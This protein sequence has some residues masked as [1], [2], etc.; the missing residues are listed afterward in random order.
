MTT[1]HHGKFCVLDLSVVIPV[2]NE[3]RHLS[4]Q[5]DA[6]LDQPW[7][8][9]WEIVVVDNGSTDGTAQVVHRYRDQMPPVRLIDASERAA[10]AYAMHVGVHAASGAAIAFCD[11]DDV[12]GDGWVAAVAAGLREHQVVTGPHELDRLNPRW[13]ADSRG[14]TADEAPVGSFSGLFPCIRGANWGIRRDTWDRLGGVREGFH[15]EDIEFSLRCWLAGVQVAGVPEASVHY[16]YRASARALWRQGWGY[17]ANRPQIARLLRDAGGPLPRPFAGWRSW[18]LL[19]AILPRLV[20][21]SGRAR[22]MWVAGN[23]FGQL[24]GSIRYRT[25]ML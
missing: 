21:T 23:R 4:A 6:L 5:L 17:G 9:G 22:W 24:A 1:P 3:Q 16:R 19:V 11:A 18:L 14:R 12:V 25:L 2:R 10:K 7:D 8:G 15:L 13:L 20:T